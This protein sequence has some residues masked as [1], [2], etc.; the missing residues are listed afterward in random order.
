LAKLENINQCQSYVSTLVKGTI[1]YLDPEYFMSQKLTK[2]S[3]VYSFGVVLLVVLSGRPALDPRAEGAQHSLVMWARQCI[4][5]GRFEELVDKNLTGKISQ[6]S[7]DEYMEVT[8]SCLLQQRTGR[9]NMSRVV[10]RLQQ[11]LEHQQQ[12]SPADTYFVKFS[13]SDNHTKSK[14]SSTPSGAAVEVEKNLNDQ[15]GTTH[16]NLKVKG[17]DGNEVLFRIKR[18]T[19]LRKPMTAYC[20]RQ[21]QEMIEISFLLNGRHVRAEQTPDELEMEDGDEIDAMLHQTGGGDHF[22]YICN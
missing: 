20:E 3:D 6:K 4:N 21:S 1:G 8:R 5:E 12:P 16:I 2:K 14:M 11:A 17:Q 10:A 9:P 22:F 13:F 15:S 7:M 19:Q 18:S